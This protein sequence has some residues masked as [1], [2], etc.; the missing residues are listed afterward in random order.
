MKEIFSCIARFAARAGPK[1]RRMQALASLSPLVPL[2]SSLDCLQAHLLFECSP[3]PVSFLQGN[4]TAVLP[5]SPGR[6]PTLV[7]SEISPFFETTLAFPLF[8]FLPLPISHTCRVFFLTL[9]SYSFPLAQKKYELLLC[10]PAGKIFGFLSRSL[11]FAY[12]P[13]LSF[14]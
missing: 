14:S 11:R 1:L 4:A 6:L 7:A 9:P 12:F 13:P 5:H 10:F 2:P 8:F 3:P